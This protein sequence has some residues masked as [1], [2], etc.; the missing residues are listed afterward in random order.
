MEE[1]VAGAGGCPAPRNAAASRTGGGKNRC[2]GPYTDQTPGTGRSCLN[3]PY[4]LISIAFSFF[5]AC[6]EC[7]AKWVKP[8]QWPRFGVGSGNVTY[9]ERRSVEK[10]PPAC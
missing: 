3:P 2:H 1:I 5:F 9:W 8:K 4:L 6:C 10:V 7:G